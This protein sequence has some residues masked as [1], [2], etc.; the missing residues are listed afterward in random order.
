MEL[1]EKKKDRKMKVYL[2]H[3]TED[4]PVPMRVFVTLRRGLLS[5]W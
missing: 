5:R 4:M 2:A 1:L 3:G